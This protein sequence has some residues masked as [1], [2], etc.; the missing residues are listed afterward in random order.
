MLPLGKI[1]VGFSPS[2]Q[3]RTAIVMGRAVAVLERMER[4]LDEIA[5][6]MRARPVEWEADT[7]TRWTVQADGSL[8]ATYGEGDRAVTAI[9]W[10]SDPT[11]G[12][13][14]RLVLSRDGEDLHCS[15]HAASTDALDEAERLGPVLA[16]AME[17]TR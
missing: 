9:L 8:R 6:L 16:E 17:G 7:S 15:E 11:T 4:R 10:G 5:G 1:R 12:S 2:S 13:A 3:V 14:V